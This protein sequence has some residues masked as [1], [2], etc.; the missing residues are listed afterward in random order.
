MVQNV[1]LPYIVIIKLS[2]I[3]IYIFFLNI[4]L[5]LIL[6]RGKLLIQKKKKI[7]A[8]KIKKKMNKFNCPFERKFKLDSFQLR[9]KKREYNFIT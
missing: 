1:P 7:M 6:W 3:Y 8:M 4:E 9:S 2:S 5:M